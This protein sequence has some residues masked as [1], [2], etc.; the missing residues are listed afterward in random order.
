MLFDEKILAK[1]DLPTYSLSNY[2]G[3][4]ALTCVLSLLKIKAQPPIKGKEV[5]LPYEAWQSVVVRY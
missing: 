2:M 4:D 3:H 1:N 5:I